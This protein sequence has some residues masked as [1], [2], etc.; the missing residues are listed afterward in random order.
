MSLTQDFG[1]FH[2]HFT[3]TT[4]W[5]CY[6][7]WYFWCTCYKI[8]KLFVIMTFNT[9]K[10]ITSDLKV[11]TYFITSNTHCPI[12]LATILLIINVSTFQISR[13]TIYTQRKKLSTPMFLLLV[14]KYVETFK[15]DVIVFSVLNV[16]MRRHTDR[17]FPVSESLS[18][19]WRHHSLR[20]K[21][22][23]QTYHDKYHEITDQTIWRTQWWPVRTLHWL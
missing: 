15:S 5:F 18:W 16:I 13:C 20:S 1:Q 11:S 2:F 6:P 19:Y 23:R 10:T 7:V 12:G 8:L 14:I 3:N 21:E 17:Y 4:L 9:E 22:K